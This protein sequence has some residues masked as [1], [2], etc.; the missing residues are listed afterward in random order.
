MSQGR[1][2]SFALFY[3]FENIFFKDLDY[4]LI[5]DGFVTKNAI[6]IIFKQL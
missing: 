3:F 6:R 5:I 2:N 1:L 4:E